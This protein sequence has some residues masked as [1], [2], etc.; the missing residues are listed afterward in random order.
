M[1]VQEGHLGTTGSLCL[2]ISCKLSEQLY[3]LLRKYFN[4]F[5]NLTIIGK[6]WKTGK[7]TLLRL[8]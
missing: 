8:C 4:T 5:I 7:E 1:L 6:F 2:R 3:G